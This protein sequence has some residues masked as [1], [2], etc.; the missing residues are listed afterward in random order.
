MPALEP[1]KD[2]LASELR[3]PSSQM[4]ALLGYLPLESALRYLIGAL[5]T[6]APQELVRLLRRNSRRDVTEWVVGGRVDCSQSF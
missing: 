5:G 3:R 1:A 2:A 6:V 4:S